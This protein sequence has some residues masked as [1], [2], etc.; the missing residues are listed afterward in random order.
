LILLKAFAAG[1]LE[2]EAAEHVQEVGTVA[3]EEGRLLEDD[4]AAW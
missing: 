2:A 3:G 1:G 4:W